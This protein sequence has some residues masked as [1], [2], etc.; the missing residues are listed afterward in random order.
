MSSMPYTTSQIIYATRYQDVWK[1]PVHHEPSLE[2]VWIEHRLGSV[3]E[4][5]A[6]THC[7]WALNAA[8]QQKSSSASSVGQLRNWN[9]N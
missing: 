4:N 5:F 8:F 3:S 1:V 9:K 6:P 7:L 2:I